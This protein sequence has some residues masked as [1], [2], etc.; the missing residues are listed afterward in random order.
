MRLTR[1][2]LV[3][4]VACVVPLVPARVIAQQQAGAAA[5]YELTTTSEVARTEYRRAVT[6]FVNTN[7]GAARRHAMKAVEA[8]PNFGVALALFARGGL[9]PDLSNADRNAAANRAVAA[10]ANATAVEALIALA[11]REQIAG[12]GAVANEILKTAATLAPNDADVQWLYYI[13]QRG[14]A[15]TPAD[16]IRMDREFLSKFD[17]GPA[18]NLLAYVLFATG[19]RA[20]AYE[21]LGKYVRSAPDQPNSHDTWADLLIMENRFDEAMRHSDGSL[22]LEPTWT[23]TPMKAGAIQLAQNKPDSARMSFARAREMSEFAAAKV[24]PSF[25]IATTYI[26]AHDVKSARRE[27][28]AMESAVASANLPAGVQALVH[29]RMALIEAYI[30]DKTAVAPH[31]AKAAEILG[32]QGAAGGNQTAIAAVSYA[33]LGDAAQAQA[34]ADAFMKAAPNN[35]FGHTLQALAA[36]TAK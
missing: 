30:G 14:A 33:A 25:W 27:M 20:E 29:Q 26:V 5:S 3:L 17:Y 21:E 24:D 32:T 2:T 35:A 28:M 22:K 34:N 11:T 4:T 23:A 15:A 31:L 9:S 12:R 16:A 8:D 6:D 36:I 18:H 13:T 19:S 1:S 10:T 7:P